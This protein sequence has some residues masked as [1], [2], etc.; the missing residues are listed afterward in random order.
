MKEKTYS[1]RAAANMFGVAQATIKAHITKGN[2]PAF[3]R[4]KKWVIKESDLLTW[5]KDNNLEK[6]N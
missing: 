4:L 1:A 3:Q 2:I 6:V 5:A